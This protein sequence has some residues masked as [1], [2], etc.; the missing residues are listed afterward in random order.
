MAN[1][2]E[3]NTTQCN[4]IE[5]QIQLNLRHDAFQ[6]YAFPSLCSLALRLQALGPRPILI[7]TVR[8]PYVLSRALSSLSYP[9]NLATTIRSDQQLLLSPSLGTNRRL[10]QSQPCGRH[11]ACQLFTPK[12]TWKQGSSPRICRKG[13]FHHS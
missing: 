4:A 10:V 7:C 1:S 5:D 3:C 2:V 11:L 12:P 6:H 13:I 8:T 9:F